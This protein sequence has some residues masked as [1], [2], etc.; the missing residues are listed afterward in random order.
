MKSKTLKRKLSL[1]KK[2]VADLNMGKMKNAYGGIKYTIP[3]TNCILCT[4]TCPF[5]CEGTCVSCGTEYPFCVCI[6]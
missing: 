6:E 1:N 3:E 4:G 5:T 2:T